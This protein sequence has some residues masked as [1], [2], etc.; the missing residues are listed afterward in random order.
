M[1]IGASHF[2]QVADVL[3]FP[4]IYAKRAGIGD[5]LTWAV[6]WHGP[7]LASTGRYIGESP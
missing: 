5:L 7:R 2:G 3:I 4:P 1:S 6:T